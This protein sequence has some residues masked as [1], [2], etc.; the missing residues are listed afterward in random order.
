M[1]L[2][3]TIR[4]VDYPLTLRVPERWDLR[5]G[6]VTILQGPTPHGPRP[7]GVI[8]LIISRRGPFPKMVMDALKPPATRTAT[9]DS[10]ARDEMRTLGKL[11]IYEMRSL[12][13]ATAQL[14]AMMKWT[15][16]AY[17][18]IDADNVRL[19]QINFL[20]LTREHFEKDRQLLESIVSSLALTEEPAQSIK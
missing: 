18:P 15:I 17:E 9:Q 5:Y 3:S 2:E 14:P 19:Y 16:S 4:L 7:D 13:P 12:Q 11:R 1:T 20:D 6:A 10:F 8:H